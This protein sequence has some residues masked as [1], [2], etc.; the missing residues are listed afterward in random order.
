MS[1]E[2]QQNEAAPEAG[3]A[4][5]AEEKKGKLFPELEELQQEIDRRIRDNK[6]FLER[7]LDEDFNDDEEA[8]DEE[9]E[10]EDFEEL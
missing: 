6:R 10:G 8:G 9:D 2:L 7:F 1:E 4:P 5:A 3:D